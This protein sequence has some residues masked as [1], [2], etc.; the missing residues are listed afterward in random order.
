MIYL[1]FILC[2]LLLLIGFGVLTTY[3]E[4]HARR[5]FGTRRRALDT[6]VARAVFII[7]HVDFAAFTRDEA[8][9]VMRH[10][11][12]LLAQGSLRGVRALERLLT[13]VARRLRAQHGVAVR[14]GTREET[15]EFVKTLSA[16][17]GRLRETM[18]EVIPVHE[19]H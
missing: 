6:L 8:R 12:H 15:R 14:R 1:F 16:F 4:K 5:F 7:A 11:G 19:Q 18:P 13:N 10:V 3:E 17:K 2:S 9:R